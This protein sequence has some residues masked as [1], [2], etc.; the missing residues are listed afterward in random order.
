MYVQD[1]GCV[2]DADQRQV[3]QTGDWMAA[4]GPYGNSEK[5]RQCPTASGYAS[6]PGECDDGVSIA[7]SDAGREQGAYAF[8]GWLYN[9]VRLEKPEP[10]ERPGNDLDVDNADPKNF[11]K[12]PVVKNT[13]AI[14]VFSDAIWMEAFPLPTDFIA[15]LYVGS[16]T[17]CDDQ[18]GRVAIDRHRK[19]VDVSFYDG[20]SQS[21]DIQK[22]WTLRWNA[23][24][25]T[26]VTL[27]NLPVQ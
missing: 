19:K 3:D 5:A 23:Q 17:S 26:P 27:P 15:D 16:Y 14:P 8:N 24:W 2:S 7:R 18:M 21:L 6:R 20:H 11:F 4:L 1:S 9:P 13:A 10:G 22:L 12:K 25:E